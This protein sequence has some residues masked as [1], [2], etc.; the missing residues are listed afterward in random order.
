MAKEAKSA[1]AWR[2]YDRIVSDAA[3][4]GVYTNPWTVEGDFECD[5]DVLTKVLSAA[6]LIEPDATK[7]QSGMAAKGIDAWLAYELR[8]AGFDGNTIWPRAESPRVLP[9][10]V[11]QLLTSLEKKNKTAAAEAQAVRS[12]L[13]AGG[14]SGGVGSADAYIMGKNYFKQVDVIMTDWDSGPEI[15]ISTKRMSASFGNNA[16]N[17]VEESYGDA[18]NLRGRHPLAAH[19]YIFAL[20]TAIFEEGRLALAHK[21]MDLLEKL[22]N[23]EDA[24]DSV[25]LLLVEGLTTTHPNIQPLVGVDVYDRLTDENQELLD[26]D[27][28]LLLQNL[29]VI[30][31]VDQVRIPAN[32]AHKNPREVVFDVSYELLPNKFMK[33]TVEQVLSAS[34][35]E[36]HSEA[37]KRR[38]WPLVVE[39]PK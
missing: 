12:R 21:L 24:Y 9:A 34:P 27:I 29:P 36:R 8:R 4:G 28:G 18:K 1:K 16:Y 7:S 20:S 17:R 39:M 15:L 31:S 5:F 11:T 19:G 6:A 13:A 25:C 38:G 32:P 26:S 2:L 30:S 23:E 22:G 14:L 37:R 35:I 3:P 10:S 33:D